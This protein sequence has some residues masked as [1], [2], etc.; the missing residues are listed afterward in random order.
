METPAHDAAVERIVHSH[1]AH[2]LMVRHVRVHDYAL[3][4]L[5]FLLPRVVQ[6]LVEAHASV[7]SG[8]F[9]T[10]EIFYGFHRFDQQGEG[11]GVRRN[12]Q[13]VLQPAFQTE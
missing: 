8:P 13:I 10:P 4:A 7:H 2:T 9:E 12:N 3:A 11:G 1:E 5:P 6:R